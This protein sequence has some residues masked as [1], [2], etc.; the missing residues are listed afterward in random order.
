MVVGRRRRRPDSLFGRAWTWAS[1]LCADWRWTDQDRYLGP[2]DRATAHPVL[3]VGNR[4]DPATRYEGAVALAD[5]L[6]R[7]ALLT[8]D[9]WGHTSLLR[10][11]CADEGRGA[12]PPRRRDARAGHRVRAGRAPVQRAAGGTVG[13]QRHGER[14]ERAAPRR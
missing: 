2:F 9:G 7:S 1:S 12:L 13:E 10:S 3:V 11:T 6:P 14:R 8:V 5:L 4:F